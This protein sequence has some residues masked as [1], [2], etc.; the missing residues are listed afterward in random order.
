MP[1]KT[2]HTQAVTNAVLAERLDTLTKTVSEGFE[3][4]HQRQDT[5]NG[6]VIKANDDIVTLQR[7]QDELKSDFKYNRIIW[8][9]LTVAVSV[10]VALTSYIIVNN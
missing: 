5:T 10:I 3:G 2:D 9:F 7:A 1:R 6:K 8:Y 4:I